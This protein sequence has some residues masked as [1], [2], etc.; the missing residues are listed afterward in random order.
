MKLHEVKPKETTSEETVDKDPPK[1]TKSVLRKEDKTN[2]P[3]KGDVVPCWYTGTLQDGAAFDTSIQM[4][5]KKKKNAKT[6][7]FEA[8]QAK[9][10]KDGLKDS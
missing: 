4:S 6:F 7:S 5:S 2:F 1:Y 10:P 9:F 8:G 3:Q